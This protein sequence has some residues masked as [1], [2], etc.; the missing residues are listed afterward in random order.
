MESAAISFVDS[1]SRIES[2]CVSHAVGRTTDGTPLAFHIY[3][4]PLERPPSRHSAIHSF[5]HSCGGALSR[6]ISSS[7]D[8]VEILQDRPGLRLSG[9]R[10]DGASAG[11]CQRPSLPIQL[12]SVESSPVCRRQH[13]LV[14]R[15]A[16]PTPSARGNLLTC[17]FPGPNLFGISTDVPEGCT[18]QQAAY[19]VRHGSR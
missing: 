1:R 7:T 15:S 8:H 17:G 9:A 16:V 14:S 12:L 3:R 2:R 18:V 11:S 6:H 19:V 4:R 10:S 5:I 13:S